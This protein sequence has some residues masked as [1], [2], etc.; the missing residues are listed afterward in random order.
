[1]SRHFRLLFFLVAICPLLSGTLVFAQPATLTEDINTTEDVSFSSEPEGFV[2]FNGVGYFFASAAPGSQGLWRTDG[3][4]EGT[5]LLKG[6]FTGDSLLA[7]DMGLF[8]AG[9]DGVSG[10]E[11]WRTNGNAEGTRVVKD[12]NGGP[13]SAFGE[14]SGFSRLF[15]GPGGMVYFAAD[16]GN[17]G[18]ALWKSDGTE[19]GTVLVKD[20]DPS[21]N[22]GAGI[23]G[24]LNGLLY[25]AA[26]DG[27]NG[28]GLWRS[29]GTDAGTT[30]VLDIT[31]GPTGTYFS[32]FAAIGN[33]F[34]FAADNGTNGYELWSSDGTMAGT[35]M[36][37]DLNPGPGDAIQLGPQVFPEVSSSHVFFS[38]SS[39]G[40]SV[41]L[42]KSDGTAIGTE[43]I[44]PGEPHSFAEAGGLLFYL[45]DDTLW[46]T[47]GTTVGT[48]LV[49]EFQDVGLDLVGLDEMVFFSADD[50][51]LDDEIWK[52]DGTEEGTVIVQ[53]IVFQGG[54][55]P[56]RLSA[57]RG[58]PLASGVVVFNA[59][60]GAHGSELWKTDGFESGTVLIKDIGVESGSS[61]PDDFAVVG[62][63]LY[64]T[65][66]SCNKGRTEWVAE[67][68]EI[69][70]VRS[71]RP[72]LRGPRYFV[73]D[74]G[75]AGSE[76]WHTNGTQAG[77][78]LVKDIYPGSEGGVSPD[79]ELVTIGSTVFFA[80]DDGVNG[81][82]LWRSDGTD[83]GT[84]MVRNIYAADG[85]S[86][87]PNML[88]DLNGVLLFRASSGQSSTEVWSSDGTEAGT[89][90]VKNLQ[91]IRSTGAVFGN[92]NPIGNLLF[93]STWGPARGFDLWRTD[94]TADG[95]I[96]LKNLRGSVTQPVPEILA[97]SG[98]LFFS[99]QD[100]IP[101]PGEDLSQ[102][103]LWKSDGTVDGT[104][105]IRPFDP[106][107]ELN[108]EQRPP[109]A[110]FS[111]IG[112]TLH[113]LVEE[114]NGARNIWKSDGTADGTVQRTELSAP[115]VSISHI[116]G[117]IAG[118]M[119][120]DVAEGVEDHSTHHVARLQGDAETLIVDETDF[121]GGL[122]PLTAAG[123]RV[124]F[125]G[126]TAETGRE[127]W[128]LPLAPTIATNGVVNAAS[129][130]VLLAPGGLA[131][132]FGVELAV[133]TLAASELPLPT[134]LGGVRV[135]VNGVDAPLL[136]VSPRQI[137]FQVPYE[138]PISSKVSVVALLGDQESLSQ[139]TPVAEFAPAMFVNP[140]SGAPIVQRHPDGALIATGN[141]AKPGDVLV[142]YV[143]GIGG[144]DNPPASGAA[145]S[146]APLAMATS[147]PVVTV[148]GVE[149]T[150]LFAG[151]APGFVG[152]GQINIQL[153]ED[154]PQGASLELVISFGAS[155]SQTLQLAF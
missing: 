62:P 98:T 43:M 134:T 18:P 83:A 67:G 82:E 48:V 144:L 38:A 150:V 96:Y 60:D 73:F 6:G 99:F 84:L 9:S 143:T 123:S 153:P 52:S 7:T 42:W 53:D 14:A 11:L 125:S 89:A 109:I 19:S 121:L 13:A 45:Q 145:A 81:T 66:A 115:V 24:Q 127:L 22:G 88:V 103:T 34:F 27:V 26:D 90:V 152:L 28:P 141:P 36:V 69:D 151:L 126:S 122:G 101:Q 112:G 17:N 94:G 77:T 142:I 2:E 78:K 79:A 97:V 116:L 3:T 149:A 154:L 105:P 15:E 57:F 113:F 137:N 1:M 47:D 37:V 56:S 86:S 65:A 10:T 147:L 46:K 155:G 21:S 54:A 8:F 93:F 85:F 68:G 44:S 71:G 35:T 61:N 5:K 102:S 133:E 129:F 138:T 49:R 50:G 120:L 70:T 30:L 20:V 118:T 95:T 124:Y 16:D 136:F 146:D 111:D 131:S 119:Y 55:S 59:D 140:N 117:S 106:V 33:T 4:E 74:D 64:F 91:K 75:D 110:D 104:E 31:P 51:N 72:W 41:D 40:G 12:I 63:D 29:D 148:G 25:L 80:A 100:K 132:L 58:D 139:P 128:A 32:S 114:F 76:L 135:Q 87:S 107:P 39:G 92:P 108:A 23:L 130:G